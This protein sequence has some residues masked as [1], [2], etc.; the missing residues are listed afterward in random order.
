MLRGG[1][2]VTTLAMTKSWW[3]RVRAGIGADSHGRVGERNRADEDVM[4]NFGLRDRDT[5][6]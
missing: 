4:D 2:N 5:E 1:M 6:L 3:T